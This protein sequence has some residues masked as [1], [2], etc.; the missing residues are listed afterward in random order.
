MSKINE[1][2]Y[3]RTK[4][5]LS[6]IFEYQRRKHNT[7]ETY[8][9][10]TRFGNVHDSRLVSFVNYRFYFQKLKGEYPDS[11]INHRKSDFN[12][13]VWMKMSDFESQNPFFRP[14]WKITDGYFTP[15]RIILWN[16]SYPQ[17]PDNFLWYKSA[18]NAFLLYHTRFPVLESMIYCRHITE[19]CILWN[20]RP[21]WFE[22]Y[23]KQKWQ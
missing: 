9:K 13:S 3:T 17:E 2:R 23:L 5:F 21:P 8:A 10:R 15:Y 20:F 11:K 16:Y 18:P 7:K 6:S 22:G 1:T 4:S 12:W 14:F 19:L